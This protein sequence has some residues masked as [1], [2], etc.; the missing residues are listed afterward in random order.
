MPS[1]AGTAKGNARVERS[2]RTDD[3]EFRRPYLPKGSGPDHLLA[4]YQ[5]WVYF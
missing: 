1:P 3:E 2:H 4:H 5:R